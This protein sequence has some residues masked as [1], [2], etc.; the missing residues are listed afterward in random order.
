MKKFFVKFITLLVT[1]CCVVSC[2]GCLID[3][4]DGSGNGSGGS[5]GS[6]SQE[7]TGC[8]TELPDS[9]QKAAAID[10][11][12]Y[13]TEERAEKSSLT[14]EEASWTVR[15]SSVAIYVT[16]GNTTSA[17]SGTIVDIDDGV[18]DANT[19]YIVT[20]HHVISS[21]GSVTVKVPDTDY[22]YGEN[23]A[24]TFTGTIGGTIAAGQQVSLVG[25]DFESDVAVL[26]LYVADNAVA[27]TIVKA[28][29]MDTKFAVKYA[30]KVFAIGNPT[31]GL[32]GSYSEGNI[33][34]D[35]RATN[36]EDIGTMYLYQIDVQIRHGSSGGGLFNK[37]GELIGITSAGDD[38]QSIFYAIPIKIDDDPSVDKGF[39]NIVKQLVAT[40]TA[41][42]YGYISSRNERFGFTAVQAT[43]TSGDSYVYVA[44]VTADSAAAK[45]GIKAGT[46]RSNG[47]NVFVTDI[48]THFEYDGVKTEITELSEF[49][50]K[51]RA[52]AV[53][54]SFTLYITR[55]ETPQ[56]GGSA[57]SSSVT[58][59]LTK[60]MSY[61]CDTGVYP[62]A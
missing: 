24:Y 15:G 23:S 60:S 43:D 50:A 14:I 25:G 26:K 41:D 22:R 57:S 27:S 59:S 48:I 5:G 38:D 51:I 35:F 28:K 36:I 3:F 54:D 4:G 20:C 30:E 7:I 44:E 9:E 13:T 61:F 40:K 12:S 8:V 58:V 62:G 2:A 21:K 29:I 52:V 19:F 45:A 37:Y 55:V 11:H 47:R 39:A 1:L 18:N 17:G 53:G 6:G 33:S 49:T 10:F 31:G 42:N 34:Y 32:P 16:Y 46:V 56:Y